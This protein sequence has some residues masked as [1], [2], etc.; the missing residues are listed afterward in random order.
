MPLA[1]GYS[2]S[3]QIFTVQG[4]AAV[5]CRI[6]VPGTE[7]ITVPF[8]TGRCWMVKL[9]VYSGQIKALEH[10]LYFSADEH[11]RLM[12]YDAGTAVM[13]LLE[14]TTAQPQTVVSDSKSGIAV[15]LPRGW[16]ACTDGTAGRYKVNWPIAN[17][18]LETWCSLLAQEMPGTMGLDTV[19]DGDIDILKGF[20]EDY[21]PRDE[22]RITITVDGVPAVH[23]VAD[24]I[25]EDKSMVEHRTYL[26][27]N[28]TVYWLAV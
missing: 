19:V 24:Y 14:V 21:T 5:E 22:S 8:G 2:T 23:Y 25:D 6:S 4:G 16:V 17:D 18:G 7:E 20:F 10:T 15:A 13:E 3:F 27:K 11:K 12:K 26:I 1:E 9:A 28:G